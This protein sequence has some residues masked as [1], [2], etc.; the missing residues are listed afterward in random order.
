MKNQLL[1]YAIF[2]LVQNSYSQVLLDFKEFTSLTTTSSI[3]LKGKVKSL[4]E[5]NCQVIDNITQKINND[6]NPVKIY[7]FDSELR[8]T[9]IITPSI[10]NNTFVY[11]KLGA[12]Q[13]LYD[14]SRNSQLYKI[15]YIFNSF[16]LVNKKTVHNSDG[17]RSSINKFDKRNNLIE[18][19]EYDNHNKI[20]TM[21]KIGYN[22]FDNPIKITTINSK[23]VITSEFLNTYLDNRLVKSTSLQPTLEGNNRFE[24][25]FSYDDKANLIT[26]ETFGGKDGLLISKTNKKYDNFGNEI[27]VIVTYK[28]NS[29]EE[30]INRSEYTYVYDEYNNWVQVTIKSGN[31]VNIKSRLIEY[32]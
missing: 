30:V 14:I 17:V 26:Q 13:T 6:C 18:I 28:N 25:F 31:S 23:N 9:S 4:K 2:F 29:G 24:Y 19:V 5:F 1:I 3:K 22:K 27:E 21:L 7:E 20:S 11:S 15:S 12:E 8:V 16:G 10:N 32:R